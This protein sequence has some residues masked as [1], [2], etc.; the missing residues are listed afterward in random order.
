MSAAAA[1][2]VWFRR[3][4][5]V[6]DHPALREAVDAGPVVCLFVLDPALLGR[7]HHR[8]PPRLRFLRAGLE[9]LDEELRSRG[10]RLVVRHGAPERIVPEVAGEAGAGA[11]HLTRDVSPF[12]RSRDWRVA[13]ALEEAGVRVRAMP[14]DHVAEPED[15]PGSSGDGYR[16]FTPFHR[17]WREVPVP[18]HVPAPRRIEG[19][20][21]GGEG[22]GR[23]P[24]GAPPLPA[25]PAAARRRLAGFVRE[26]VD[27]YQLRRDL[28]A[29]DA[30]SRLS[31]YLRLG[32]C[33]PAQIGRALGLPG[34][35]SRGREAFWRQVCWRDFY[36]HHLARNP[37]VLRAAFQP[38]LRAVRWDDDPGD[39]ASW[40]AGETGYPLV[41]AGMRQLAEVAWIH[42][43]ARLVVASFLAKDLL[44][45]WRRGETVFMRGL[46]DG[47]PASNNGGW[48]WTAGTG[49][50]AAPYFRVLNPVRQARRFD[51]RGEYVRR[52]VPELRGV[53]DDRIFEPWTMTAEEQRA[54]RCR[55]GSDYPAPRVDHGE[56]RGLAIERYREARGDG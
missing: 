52:Y 29:E 33:T 36:H 50:D 9:A 23:L 28:L 10:G 7:R 17:A 56:R 12:A 25:G 3:D 42:N 24:A 13:A 8:A 18:D 30:T 26:A 41:D 27:A 38:G 44:V 20:E 16:A 48:Q 2:V 54:A 1:T 5:R 45:D 53:P 37:E 6:A 47:D 32:M 43:R 11:V 51:P 55:I 15:L 14:G 40:S 22:L 49:T 19:P 46:V 39:L 4:L 34:R 21:L 35:L 31:A